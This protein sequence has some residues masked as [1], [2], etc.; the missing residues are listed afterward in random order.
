MKAVINTR[1]VKTWRRYPQYQSVDTGWLTE[2]PSHWGFM[3]LKWT[4]DECQNGIWGDEPTG[5][6]G[7]D[8]GCVR[9]ADFNR[10]SL[11][12]SNDIELTQ[13]SVPPSK[14]E[15]RILR[16]G[17]LLL[18]KSGGGDLQPVGALVLF[19]SDAEAVC[20]NFIAR[21]SVKDG[22]SPS[23]LRYLHAA[24][25]AARVNTRSMKQSTGIQNLDSD[26]YFDEKAGHP[27]LSEQR[28]IAAFLDRETSRID[29][30]IGHKRRLIALLEEKRQAVISHAVTKGLDPD[31]ETKDSGISWLGGVPGQWHMTRLKFVADVQTG[32]T[33]GKNYGDRTLVE[34]PYLRVA[35]VQ[36]GFLDLDEI[37]KV[38]VPENDVSRHLLQPGDV[39]MT[40]G[41]DFDKLGRGYVWEGQIP[42]CLHQNHIFAVRPYQNKLLPHFLAAVMTSWHGRTYFTYTSQQSTNLASTNST[43]L[44]NFPIPLPDVSVQAKVLQ[45]I[46]ESSAALTKCVAQ[47]EA[48]VQ[49]LREYRSA[50]ISAAVTGQIDVREEVQLDE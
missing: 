20:S 40:E 21:V 45:S 9:V 29:A 12:V 35:N 18:E 2:I 42:D 39:L 33:L 25:Y 26:Q 13:R 11:V 32:L 17:D 23:Y 4:I 31:A 47:I 14:R 50:L 24:L 6:D 38:E 36:D 48:G 22:N 7:E 10:D 49:H 15:G 28:A 19:D 43:K 27:P 46:T 34:R 8:I 16:R 44:G 1:R 30:L 41:G 5:V 37:T 3:R